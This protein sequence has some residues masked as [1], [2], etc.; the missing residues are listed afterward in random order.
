MKP[1]YTALGL[2]IGL[3]IISCEQKN[4]GPKPVKKAIETKYMKPE[5]SP[6]DDFYTYVNGTW[7]EQTPIPEDRDSWGSF[8]ELRAD[9]EHLLYDELKKGIK[10][11]QQSGNDDVAKTI[12]FFKVAM[13]SVLAETVGITPVTPILEQINQVTTF[14]EALNLL[15][16][17]HNKGIGGLFGSYVYEDK[18]NSKMMTLYL[19]QSGLSLPDRD[20]YL[21]DTE[22]YQKYRQEYVATIQKMFE[23]AGMDAEIAQKDAAAVLKLETQMAEEFMS[24]V[25]RRN[26]LNTYHRMSLDRLQEIS[27]S[28][29]WQAYFTGRGLPNIDTLIVSQPDYMEFVS[30]L[31]PK[32]DLGTLQAYLKW[33]SIRSFAPYL[34]EAFVATH[35]KFFSETLRGVK[36]REPRWRKMVSLTNAMIG[37]GLGQMYVKRA[38]SKEA[39]E[40]V[41]QMVEKIREALAVRIDNLEWM[42]GETKKQAHKKLTAIQVKIGY[43]D[44]WRDYGTMQI[45]DESLVNNVLEARRFENN[46]RMNRYGKP[47]DRMEWGMTPQTVNAYYSPLKNEIV[48]PAGILQPPFYSLDADAAVNFGGIGAVIGHEITHGFDDSGRR[49]DWEGNLKNWWTAED[50]ERFQERAQVLVEQFNEYKVLDSLNVNGRLT[51]GEN[52]ADLGGILLAYDALQLY[53]KENERPGDI[54]GFSPEQRFFLSWATVWRR[55]IRDE[56]QRQLILTDS[57]SPGQFRANGPI[58][59]VPAFFEAFAVA[60]NSP[61]RRPDSAHVKIW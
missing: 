59:N 21:K 17:L 6:A 33:K 19:S 12:Q 39:K 9:N 38:F 29:N 50:N 25:E 56:R 49:Y 36:E 11:D 44:Q 35:H 61:M 1:R 48:F 51:L 3:L 47:S 45:G 37:E 10:N 41:K 13:D 60:E 40:D 2:A 53:L 52:I 32:T 46:R 30:E 24:R 43:P 27:P 14:Q 15:P 4:S 20:Y 8:H 18:G 42:S 22:V 55:N 31:L 26:P 58:S 7:L 28:V 5:V 57:H 23:L 16:E 54:D 34:S